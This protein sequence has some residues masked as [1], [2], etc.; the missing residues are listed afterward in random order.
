MLLNELLHLALSALSA[1]S[2]IF[3][4]LRMQGYTHSEMLSAINF[5]KELYEGARNHHINIV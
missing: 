4:T 1:G 3:H 5:S 2:V